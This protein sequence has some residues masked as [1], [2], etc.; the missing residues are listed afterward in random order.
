MN[1]SQNQ[2]K[3]KIKIVDVIH[4]YWNGLGSLW[5]DYLVHHICFLGNFCITLLILNLLKLGTNSEAYNVL[6]LGCLGH[7]EPSMVMIVLIKCL[8]KLRFGL[9][10]MP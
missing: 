2:S 1:L 5:K 3:I 4:S 7:V 8:V 6:A 10:I 9:S